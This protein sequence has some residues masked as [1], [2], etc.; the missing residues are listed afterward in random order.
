MGFGDLGNAVIIITIFILIQFLLTLSA[1]V[2]N[3]KNNWDLYKCNPAVLPFA[4]MFGH[5]TQQTFN[6]CVKNS[7]VNFMSVFLEPIY[8][9]LGY[10]ASNGAIFTELFQRLKLF[11]DA[12][13]AAMGDFAGITSMRLRGLV[14]AT[15]DVYINIT[16]SFSKITATVAI[17]YRAIQSSLFMG[18]QAKYE[19]PNTIISLATGSPRNTRASYDAAKDLDENYN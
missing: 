10:F 13:D 17:L 2:A 5:N 14:S 4:S 19:L 6:E 18:K 8:A 9:S 3:I 7:Q 12:E 1:G 16:D 15:N 11:G